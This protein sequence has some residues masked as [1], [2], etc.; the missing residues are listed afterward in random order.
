VMISVGDSMGYPMVLT[1]P[2]RSLESSAGEHIVRVDD[3][4]AKRQE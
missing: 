1:A 2:R 4:G 3:H